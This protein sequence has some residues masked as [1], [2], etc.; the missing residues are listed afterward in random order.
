MASTKRTM[1]LAALVL[2]AF[3]CHAATRSKAEDG[4]TTTRAVTTKSVNADGTVDFLGSDRV[5]QPVR[6]N[7]QPATDIKEAAYSRILGQGRISGERHGLNIQP[8]VG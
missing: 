7:R 4:R 1:T 2:L 5:C 8:R 6:E 3:V